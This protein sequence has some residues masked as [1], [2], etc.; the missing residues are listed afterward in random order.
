MSLD[1][2]Y[3][4]KFVS[5]KD[6][7]NIIKFYNTLGLCY[8][9]N[10]AI[11]YFKDKNKENYM[12]CYIYIDKFTKFEFNEELYN[13]CHSDYIKYYSKNP[14]TKFIIY[15]NN[16]KANIWCKTFLKFFN[17]MYYYKFDKNN[18]NIDYYWQ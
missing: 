15:T 5:V 2:T 10:Y 7:K 3:N 12:V 1:I 9:I 16:K 8:D 4:I 14:N 11:N 6:E 13:M 17:C 18:D